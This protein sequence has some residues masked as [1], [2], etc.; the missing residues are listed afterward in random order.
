[1]KR[2]IIALIL[3]CIVITIVITVP[4]FYKNKTKMENFMT[5]KNRLE[6]SNEKYKELFNSYP[7]PEKETDPE[8][9]L[10]LRKS[11]FSDVFNSGVID[12]KT[13]ELTTIVALATMQTLPQL[14]SHINAGL[15]IGLEPIEIREAIYQLAPF[16]GFPKTLNAVN[17][18][19][20]VF[21]QK[22]IK[23]PMEN[24]GTTN[25]ENRHEKGLA[26]QEPIY[27]DEI[28]EKYKNLPANFNNFVPEFLTDFAFG[29][30]YTRNGLD[31]KTRELMILVVLTTNGNDTQIKSHIIGNLKVGNSKEVITA[32][33]VHL[34]P[35]IGF[36]NVFNA[37]NIMEEID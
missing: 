24:Q 8:L 28:K 33:L 15:N 11:I 27:G 21:K 7:E 37:L 4:C 32:T 29:D 20:E 10:I 22:N 31:I 17:V 26:I 13:R 19:N 1:M 6:L 36:P 35:Y 23:L 30:F 5:N 12:D 9:M 16:I 2:N 25:D 18:M 14:N 3:M 34:I